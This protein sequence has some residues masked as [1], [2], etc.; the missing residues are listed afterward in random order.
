[1]SNTTKIKGRMRSITSTQKITQA[2][3]L[4]SL[5]KLQQYKRQMA[6]FDV[7]YDALKDSNT[8]F[9]GFSKS[10][11][12]LPSVY[13]VFMPDLGLCSSYTNGMSRFIK[14]H[15][16]KEDS[17]VLIGTQHYDALGKQDFTI[18]NDVV[19]S[20]KFELDDALDYLNI[21]TIFVHLCPN[22]K[23]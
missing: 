6:S 22:I 10:D 15:A 5:S 7:Y 2:M 19:S 3:K 18:L 1:M 21:L 17:V 16:N 20:E 23:A 11:D 13:L 14:Q 12:N 8:K 4:V 9:I